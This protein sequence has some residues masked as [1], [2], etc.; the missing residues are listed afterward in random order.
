[1]KRLLLAAVCL[2]TFVSAAP[3][4]LAGVYSDD[5]AKC[6]VRSASSDDRA[7]LVKWIF[8]TLSANPAASSMA[9]VDDAAS[10]TASREAAALFQ[11]LVLKDCRAESI[12]A[13]KNE[14]ELAMQQSFQVLGQAAMR[15]LMS[16]PA[17]NARMEAFASHA[18][19]SKWEA[20][21]A[22]AI[23]QTPAPTK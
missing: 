1:M 8:S 7:L 18:D 3:A 6:L 9:K 2:T 5:M 22:E 16:H 20:L 11:R 17:V 10:E 15:E 12:A 19:E 13:I 14:G 4:A 23:G 21:V